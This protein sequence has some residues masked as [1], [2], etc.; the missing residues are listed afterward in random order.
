SRRRHTRLQGDWSSDVCSSDLIRYTATP[1]PATAGCSRTVIIALQQCGRPEPIAYTALPVLS[2]PFTD[3][4]SRGYRDPPAPR[5]AGAQIGRA[6]CRE[7]G[8]SAGRAVAV[9]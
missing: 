7:R 6:S 8:G 5:L 9:R 1:Y 4:R 2:P 3:V